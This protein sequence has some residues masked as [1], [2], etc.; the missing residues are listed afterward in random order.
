MQ[1]ALFSTL[2]NRAKLFKLRQILLTNCL[3]CSYAATASA[4]GIRTVLF[5][6]AFICKWSFLGEINTTCF[7]FW[8]ML[9]VETNNAPVC[10]G[11]IVLQ[12]TIKVPFDSLLFQ[13]PSLIIQLLSF[14]KSNFYLDMSFRKV[15]FC[16]YYWVSF[17]KYSPCEF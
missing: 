13:N 9:P 12:Y 8:P 11:L 7:I 3:F 14:S 6:F 15:H 17:F 4:L 5:S 2:N 10:K 16:R 1:S